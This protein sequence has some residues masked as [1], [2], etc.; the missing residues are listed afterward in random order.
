MFIHVRVGRFLVFGRGS[1]Y[2]LVQSGRHGPRLT[3]V[4]K[5]RDTLAM[6]RGST[7][8]GGREARRARD[9][10][11]SL[12]SFLETSILESNQLIRLG[13]RL[14]LLLV[15]RTCVSCVCVVLLYVCPRA[16]PHVCPGLVMS[17]YLVGCV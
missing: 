5:S 16:R 11:F 14:L 1:S 3:L 7:V 9:L 8:V 4:K 12:E 2:K 17:A 13:D 6:R 15:H 10:S